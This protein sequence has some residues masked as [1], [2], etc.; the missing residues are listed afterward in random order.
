MYFDTLILLVLKEIFRDPY[1]VNHIYNIVLN[2]SEYANAR[3]EPHA[4]PPIKDKFGLS[5]SIISF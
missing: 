5:K 4:P 1:L 3:D 2:F